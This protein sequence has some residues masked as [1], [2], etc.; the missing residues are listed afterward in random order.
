MLN[1]GVVRTTFIISFL[2]H[3]LFVSLPAINLNNA[4]LYRQ[5]DISFKIEMEKPPLLPKIDIMDKEKRLKEIMKKPEPVEPETESLSEEVIVEEAI[6]ESV[7]EDIKIVDP[8]QEAMLRYQDMVKQK[9]EEVRRYPSWAKRQGIEGTV[10]LCFI[11][12][13]CG[14]SQDVEIICS[15]GSKILDE[16]AIATIKRANPFQAVPEEICSSSVKIEISLVFT[17]E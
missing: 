3:C 11:V 2:G 9:I 4:N 14:L 17:L 7:E 12:L 13:T 6:K 16:E 1:D 8:A 10:G 15:S 5:E